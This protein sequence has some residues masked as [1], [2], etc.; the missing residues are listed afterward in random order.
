LI[1]DKTDLWFI[2]YDIRDL[3][4]LRRVH[5]CL[6]KSALSLQYSAFCLEGSEQDA[7]RVLDQLNRIIDASKDDIRAYRLPHAIK[8][9]K[10]GPQGLPSCLTMTGTAALTALLQCT[11]N[12]DESTKVD[13]EPTEVLTDLTILSAPGV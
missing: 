11:S 3:G 9:W 10:L 6:K 4:R 8:V 13:Q 7:L 1:H 12:Q 5:R 2:A